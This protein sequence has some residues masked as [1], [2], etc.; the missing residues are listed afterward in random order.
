[1][2]PNPRDSAQME[3]FREAV[4]VCELADLGY[5][6][7]DWTFEKRVRG[8]GFCR[9]RLDRALASASWSHIFPFARVEHLTAVKSDHSPILLLNEMETGNQRIAV[10]KPFRY[11]CVWERDSRFNGIVEDAWRSD[12]PASSVTELSNK[13]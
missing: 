9:V 5:C 10:K 1:M 4:D 3:G 6:G 12:G 2:G 8:G 7:L 13:L 11:E